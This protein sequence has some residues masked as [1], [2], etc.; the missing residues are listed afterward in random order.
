MFSLKTNV[1]RFAGLLMILFIG[2]AG[3]NAQNNLKKWETFDFAKQKI[4]A[5]QIKNLDHEGLQQLRG[6]VFGKRGRVFKE[7]TIQEY[8]EKRTWYKPNPN[9]SNSVLSQNERLNLDTI[10]LAEAANHDIVEPGDLRYWEKKPIP[11]DKI[12][13]A[14]AAEWR[15]MIAEIEAIHG[16]TFPEEPWLQKYFE[17]RYWYKANPRYS[18]TVLTDIERQNIEAITKKRELERKVAVSPGDMDKFQTVLLTDQMLENLTLSELRQ[19]KNEFWARRGRTFTLPGVRQ[20]FEW[21]EWYRPAKDQKT[22]KLSDIEQQNV[23]LI[24][25]RE[26]KLRDEIATKPVE[27]D[28]FAGMFT[29]DLRVLRN[30]IYARRGKVFRSKD[31]KDYF[32]A[33]TWYKPDPNFKD[34]MLSSI[35]KANLAVIKEAEDMAASKFSEEEG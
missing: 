27:V 30:E 3:V 13:A 17:E 20:M 32:A 22:V 35:E 16:K 1:L 15:I 4:T 25:R 14:T 28:M 31:L 9:F 23:S 34:E 10:R 19:M 12:Y 7:K 5:A 24:E 26:K 8:L 18:P 29:E 33:Q 21:Q 11:E 6:I 2:Y